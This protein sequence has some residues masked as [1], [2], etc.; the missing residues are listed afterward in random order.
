MVELRGSS[1]VEQFLTR[2]KPADE[3][4][5]IRLVSNTEE[6][7]DIRPTFVRMLDG[8]REQVVIEHAYM[9]D[10][11]VVVQLVALS[12]R[13]VRITIILPQRMQLHN[14]ATQLAIGQLMSDGN[15]ANIRVFIFPGYCHSKIV[16][17]DSQTALRCLRHFLHHQKYPKSLQ[18]PTTATARSWSRVIS[19][20][21]FTHDARR[22]AM[23]ENRS[24]PDTPQGVGST[25]RRTGRIR[26]CAVEHRPKF[27]LL[28]GLLI[29][30]TRAGTA[31]RVPITH[32]TVRQEGDGVSGAEGT[33]Q[34][35]QAPDEKRFQRLTSR[36]LCMN[37]SDLLALQKYRSCRY[38]SLQ[39]FLGA[40]MSLLPIGIHPIHHF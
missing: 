8:A 3:H 22:F 12:K 13:G 6:S 23:G 5:A 40:W 1:F 34:G 37:S 24:Y 15:L 39:K 27:Q 16:L 33:G 4:T 14:H 9:S 32:T 25:L 35:S 28:H 31:S 20:Q 26:S 21:G 7:K 29:G 19:L 18:R 17:V 30:D 11:E 2:K 36:C 10:P 38:V